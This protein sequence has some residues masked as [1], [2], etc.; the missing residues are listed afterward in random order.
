MAR[1]LGGKVNIFSHTII[2]LST[3]NLELTE[4]NEVSKGD[5]L[6]ALTGLGSTYISHISPKHHS[7]LLGLIGK[8]MYGELLP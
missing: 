7:E 6:S 2:H 5:H 3:E 8:K 4:S 1:K